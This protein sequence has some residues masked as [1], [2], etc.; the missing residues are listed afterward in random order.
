M[1]HYDTNHLRAMKRNN[2]TMYSNE[3]IKTVPPVTNP[4]FS[5]LDEMKTVY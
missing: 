1:Y 2:Q 3:S 5:C 4:S